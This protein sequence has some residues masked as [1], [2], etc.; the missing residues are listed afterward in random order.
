MSCAGMGHRRRAQAGFTLVEV[1]MALVIFA[2]SV[3]GLV[4]LESRSIESQKA[5]AQIR[6]AERVAQ[7]TMAELTSRGFLELVRTD[8]EGNPAPAFPYDD[9]NVGS[10][11]RLR[12]FRSPPADTTDAPPGSVQGQFIVFRT[13]DWV[14]DLASPPSNPPLATD[15]PLI[16]ALMLD[17]TVLWIDDTNPAFPPP[18][19]ATVQSLEPSM[20]VPGDPDFAPYVGH[21]QLRTIRAND[22]V[23]EVP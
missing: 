11:Q 4:G 1:L 7:E 12:A 6:E 17:V 8:F 21:V 3:V 5:S 20:V 16:N 23:V 9:S 10:E 2:I 15:V 19:D 22:A 18:A 13:V 14:V